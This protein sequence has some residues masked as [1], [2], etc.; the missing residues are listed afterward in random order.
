MLISVE[1][2]VFAC[3]DLGG[4]GLIMAIRWRGQCIWA[5]TTGKDIGIGRGSTNFELV[6][7]AGCILVGLAVAVGFEHL[8][9]EQHLGDVPA[10]NSEDC[11]SAT[12]PVDPQDKHVNAH[13]P[14]PHKHGHVGGNTPT[15]RTPDYAPQPLPPPRL[16]GEGAVRI[17]RARRRRVERARRLAERARRRRVAKGVLTADAA[18]FRRVLRLLPMVARRRRVACCHRPK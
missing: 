14:Q 9:T 4:S 12:T 5:R 17:P 13:R 3:C 10:N 16:T 8:G 1:T 6:L 18:H 11:K 2:S 7:V 15:G